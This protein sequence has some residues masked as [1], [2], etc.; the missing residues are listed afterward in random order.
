MSVSP[1][2]NDL[3]KPEERLNKLEIRRAKLAGNLK[4][5]L[6]RRKMSRKDQ[7]KNASNVS[8]EL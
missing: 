3:L 1:S 6:Q 5:N 7:E 8:K 4:Q 2:N